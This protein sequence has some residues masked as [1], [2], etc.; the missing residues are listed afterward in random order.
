MLKPEGYSVVDA[1]AL[2]LLVSGELVLLL[3]SGAVVSLLV[4]TVSVFVD[5]SSFFTAALLVLRLSVIYQPE[6][7]KTTPTG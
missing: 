1:V 6:P 5:E 3:V 4:S 7:L 2:L